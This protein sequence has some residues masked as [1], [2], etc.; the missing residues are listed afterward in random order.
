MM[1]LLYILILMFPVPLY[2]WW[3]LRRRSQWTPGKRSAFKWLGYFVLAVNFFA[4]AF[5]QTDWRED[6]ASDYKSKA[7]EQA[8]RNFIESNDAATALM[9]ALRANGIDD[10]LVIHAR[11]SKHGLIYIQVT[12]AW[13]LLPKFEQDQNREII[14]LLLKKVHPPNGYP[15]VL[16]D[17]MGKTI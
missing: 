13:Q 9:N 6:I 12:N 8:D 11:P 10:S 17:I 16:K 4:L 3:Y 14:R 15:F 2:V 7:A 5:I 1:V